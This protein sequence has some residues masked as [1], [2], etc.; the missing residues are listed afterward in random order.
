MK[1]GGGGLGSRVVE[2]IMEVNLNIS[3]LPL[4]FL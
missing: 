2:T 1:D 4:P 3:P